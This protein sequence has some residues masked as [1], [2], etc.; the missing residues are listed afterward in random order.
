MPDIAKQPAL[1]DREA[2]LAKDY[3]ANA[4]GTYMKLT[5]NPSFAAWPKTGAISW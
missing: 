4:A 5:G 2:A 3:L 1:R